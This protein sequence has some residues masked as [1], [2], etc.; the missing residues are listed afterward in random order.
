MSITDLLKRMD[1]YQKQIH[2]YF[3]SN[4]LCY[5]DF[6]DKTD[7]YWYISDE[8]SKTYFQKEE[9]TEDNIESGSGLYSGIVSSRVFRTDDYTMVALDHEMGSDP[10]LTIF[11]NTKELKIDSLRVMLEE[12][13]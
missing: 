10:E 1:N 11:D 6:D 9:F 5:L 2:D 4:D 7:M 3:G 12:Y 8:M 13:W